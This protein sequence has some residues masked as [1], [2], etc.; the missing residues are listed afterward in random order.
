MLPCFLLGG[1]AKELC[2]YLII[3][4]CTTMLGFCV[5]VSSFQ[6]VFV[7]QAVVLV[8]WWFTKR[9]K[10]VLLLIYR[11][12]LTT[13]GSLLWLS[14]TNICAVAP[15]AC[16]SSF[17]WCFDP[18]HREVRYWGQMG[19][20]VSSYRAQE[21]VNNIYIKNNNLFNILL[22]TFQIFIT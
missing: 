10:Y 8:I 15:A 7:F 11:L 2:L 9:H 13:N 18:P 19:Q 22:Q 4:G 21:N 1:V 3:I 16:C 14:S 17:P 12:F 6:C 20:L 5:C